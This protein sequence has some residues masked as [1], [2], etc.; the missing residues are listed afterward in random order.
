MPPQLALILCLSAVFWLW[1]RDQR[2]NPTV[3]AALWIPVAWFSIIGSRFPSEWFATHGPKTAN[4]LV[5]GSP[6]DRN[7]FLFLL[8]LGIVVLL[9]RQVKWGLVIRR[10]PW[11]AAFFLY[12]AISIFWSDFP[13]TA[14]KRWHKVFG[15]V[16]MALIVWTES[17]ADKAVASLLRRSGYVLILVSILFIKYFPDLGRGYSAWEFELMITGITT[18]KNLLGNTCLIVGLFFVSSLWIRDQSGTPAPTAGAPT[19]R[20][21]FYIDA[22]FVV[23]TFWVLRLADSATSL[24]CLLIGSG[25]V[26]I[27]QAPGIARRFTPLLIGTAV[28]LGALQISMNLK[29][30]VITSLGRDVTL[31]GRTELWDELYQFQTNVLFGVGFESFWLGERIEKLWA[32]HWWKPNQAHNGYYE[33][34]LNIGAVGLFLQCA[35]MLACYRQARQKMLALLESGAT[36]TVGFA[37]ARFSLAY[38]LVLGLYNMTEATF[39]ALHLSFFVFFLVTTQYALPEPSLAQAPAPSAPGNRP[40]PLPSWRPAAAAP[41][42][43]PRLGFRGGIRDKAR[44]VRL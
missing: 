17:D 20:T 19:L 33:T 27:T 3:S 32:M 10:N 34:Y 9:R 7:V 4:A 21:D 42:A 16:V 12:T 8:V 14:F 23:L 1:W 25:V 36:R 31:T 29:D 28:I 41:V 6:L 13:F 2:N 43:A 18:N 35:M 37:V 5:E 44:E 24:L 38:L 15:H 26:V 39:K 11:I 22:A 40:R 30:V